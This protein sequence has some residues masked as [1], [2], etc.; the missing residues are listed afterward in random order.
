M[1]TLHVTS[2]VGDKVLFNTYLS[3]LGLGIMKVYVA[4]IMTPVRRTTPHRWV[5]YESALA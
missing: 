3:F 1:Q 2:T 5:L 4:S